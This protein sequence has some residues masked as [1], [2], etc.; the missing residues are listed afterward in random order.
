[1]PDIKI[2]E[3]KEPDAQQ[4][5]EDVLSNTEAVDGKNNLTV[6]EANKKINS[7]K[8]EWEKKINIHNEKHIIYEKIS[9]E[10]NQLYADTMA[11]EYI[12]HNPNIIMFNSLNIF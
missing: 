9:N 7:L 8:E 3:I 2:E 1:M 11:L 12:K 5:K 10:L 6:D 4:E